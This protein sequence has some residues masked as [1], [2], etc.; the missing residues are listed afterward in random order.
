VT[1][2]HIIRPLT[3]IKEVISGGDL[4]DRSSAS[5]QE[6]EEDCIRAAPQTGGYCRQMRAS[7]RLRLPSGGVVELLPGDL[8]GRT[9][10]AALT[11]DDPRI[12]EA[13]A[14]VSL[15]DG[16][17]QLL[18]LRRM[19]AVDGRPV[20]SA[21]LR[22]G[23]VVQLADGIALTVERVHLPDSLQA[24][25]VPGL[26]RRL[27]GSVASVHA[28][29]TLRVC[30]RFEPGAEAHVWLTDGS[31]RLQR[32]NEPARPLRPGDSFEVDGRDVR[33]VAVPLS[34]ASHTPTR[35]EGGVQAP[36]RIEARFD[37]VHIHREGRPPLVL[38]GRGARIVSELV[39]MGGPVPWQVLAAEVWSGH[40]EPRVLR[41]R[42]DVNLARLRSRLREAGVRSDLVRSN[43][44]GQ[45]EL[46]LHDADRVEDRT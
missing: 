41:R 24:L 27:L 15:R 38:S 37:S 17:L 7:A 6:A 9:S 19:I 44:A 32:R 33:L 13:H 8:I 46:V 5:C 3:L 1:I 10:S 26:G 36:L 30:N 2:Y 43:G 4:E 42:L 16:G 18:S 34:S 31:P 28:G 22:A 21:V 11:L 20:A 29:V 25:E 39:C 12:S 23:L 35:V 40:S 14:M 45:V